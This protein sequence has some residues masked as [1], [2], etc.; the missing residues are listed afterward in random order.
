M[1]ITHPPRQTRHKRLVSARTATPYRHT[2]Q[3]HGR[4][5]GERERHTGDCGRVAPRQGTVSRG[6]LRPFGRSL[7]RLSRHVFLGEMAGLRG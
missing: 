7:E 5:T 2:P 6:G 1:F 4:A 3:S